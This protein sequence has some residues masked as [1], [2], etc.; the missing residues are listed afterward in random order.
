[1]V[2]IMVMMMVLM[3]FMMMVMLLVIMVVM[4]VVMVGRLGITMQSLCLKDSGPGTRAK[5]VSTTEL[6]K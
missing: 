5:Q 1:M 6:T 4:M 3:T 2:M